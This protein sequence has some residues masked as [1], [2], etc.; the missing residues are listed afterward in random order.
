MSA[1]AWLITC[2]TGNHVGSG[3]RCLVEDSKS[4]IIRTTRVS[5]SSITVTRFF[6]AA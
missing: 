2:S 4:G 5:C 3:W 6:I 1:T